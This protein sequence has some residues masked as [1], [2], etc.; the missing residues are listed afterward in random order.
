MDSFCALALQ[1]EKLDRANIEKRAYSVNE[2]IPTDNMTRNIIIWSFYQILVCLFFIYCSEMLFL[3]PY[4]HQ[5]AF[6]WTAEDAL[7]SIEAGDNPLKIEGEPSPKLQVYTVVFNVIVFM[8]VF[9]MFNARILDQKEVK[10]NVKDAWEHYNNWFWGI[11][12]MII[13]AQVCFVEFGGKIFRVT[14]LTFEMWGLSIIFGAGALFWHMLAM[15]IPA[16]WFECLM[17]CMPKA[18]SDIVEEQKPQPEIKKVEPASPVA[19]NKDDDFVKAEDATPA[20]DKPKDK[21]V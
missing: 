11:L 20:E 6:Y 19:E 2:R 8:N 3:V 16:S 15:K 21:T 17:K 7:L 5:D 14:N 9:N 13:I 12:I 1:H 10:N 18:S 4:S